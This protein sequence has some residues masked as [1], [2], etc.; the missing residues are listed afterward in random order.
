M[1]L[2][3][4]QLQ[5]N[6][7]DSEYRMFKSFK[8]KLM[9]KPVLSHFNDHAKIILATKGSKKGLGVILQQ[10]NKNH[11]NHKIHPVSKKLNTA[12]GIRI[13]NSSLNALHRGC[14]YFR[15]YLRGRIYTT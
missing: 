3:Q 13:R 1:Y 14:I 9:N 8:L 6:K 5:R 11:K 2:P 4:G 7:T 10:I 15:Q 12:F